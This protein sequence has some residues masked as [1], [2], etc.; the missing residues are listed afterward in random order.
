MPS[1]LKDSQKGIVE[2]KFST[3]PFV[4]QKLLR[5]KHMQLTRSMLFQFF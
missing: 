1:V 5:I 2:S 3:I 4:F